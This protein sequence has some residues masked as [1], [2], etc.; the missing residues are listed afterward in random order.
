MNLRRPAA[1]ATLAALAL[2]L[3]ACSSPSPASAPTPPGAPAPQTM[4]V[5]AAASLTDVFTEL[6]SA[7]E[8]AHPGVSVSLTFAGSSDLAAQI[9]EG[10]PAD[11]FA[12]ANEKQME[13]AAAEVDGEPALFATN[14]LTIVVP[15]G[16][17][18]G[19]TDFA[20]L[21]APGLLLVTCAPEVPCG[22]ATASLEQQLGVTL[23]PVSQ[24]ANV[25]D[26]LGKVAAG[27]ADAGLV[28]VTDVARASGVEAIPFAGSE[29]AVNRYPI[30][31]LITGDAPGA[32]RD[33]VA[34]VLG[35]EGRAALARAGFQAP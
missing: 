30:A 32:A 10:A 1:R 5:F 18:A 31:A 7:Y 21:A 4:D 26:V 11:V 34:Y 2:A 27:E 6:A 12:S 20:S 28:Y 33:F 23:S 25:T 29:L 15:E 24:E 16:N 13:A 22:A 17:P 8:D 14:T 35:P 19:V 9:T 3:A